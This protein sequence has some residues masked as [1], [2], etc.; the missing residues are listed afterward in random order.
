MAAEDAEMLRR[1]VSALSRET[2]ER[3]TGSEGKR[4]RVDDLRRRILN[5]SRDLASVLTRLTAD[6][7]RAALRA[8]SADGPD[9]PRSPR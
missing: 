3:L 1:V 6:E 2:L 9:A 7:M 5:S 8:M 4:S